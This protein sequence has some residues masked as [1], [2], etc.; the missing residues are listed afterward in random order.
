[1]IHIYILVLQR[2]TEE[3]GESNKPVLHSRVTASKQTKELI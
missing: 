3:S 1:M 2:L